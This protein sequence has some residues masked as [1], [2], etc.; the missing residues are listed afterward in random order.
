VLL[1]AAMP[2]AG[3]LAA[4]FTYE[5]DDLGRLKRATQ[6]TGTQITYTLD[7]AGNR[8][9]VA[10]GTTTAGTLSISPA[11]YTVTEGAVSVSV[12]VARSGG[13]SGAV[14]VRY[15]TADGTAVGGTDFM[16]V[17]GQLSWA[18]G[19]VAT[20][21]F[22]VPILNDAVSESTEQFTV[23]LSSVTGGAAL[24]TVTGTVTINDDDSTAPSVPTG[25]GLSSGTSPVFTGNYTIRWN[26]S[27]GS[28]NRYELAEDL[29]A[30]GTFE[31]TYTI[32]APATSKAFSKGANY[33]EFQYKVRACNASNACSAWS[34][35]YILIVCGQ[36]YCP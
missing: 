16:P 18:S 15:A 6:S 21:S 26:A 1:A 35:N 19:D 5:Y 7:P 10:T 34:S 28:P 12:S 22:S 23:N 11:T 8:T 25:L 4:T 13:S 20:K 32:T 2:L 29:N 33:F 27:T 9:A 24:G 3:A 36:G 17:S 14:S 31:T 30:D